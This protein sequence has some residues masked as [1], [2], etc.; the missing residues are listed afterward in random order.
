[1]HTK[2]YSLLGVFRILFGALF[3]YFCMF[4]L[5]FQ[6]PLL[7]HE[8]PFSSTLH[9]SMPAGSVELWNRSRELNSQLAGSDAV[10]ELG[11]IIFFFAFMF[12]LFTGVIGYWAYPARRNMAL[13]LCA[14]N[15]TACVSYTISRL[16]L[17]PV[18]E[19]FMGQPLTP[20]RYVQWSC[21]SSMLIYM[22]ASIGKATDAQ[23]LQA[24]VMEFLCIIT[25]FLGSY[26]AWPWWPI[27]SALS[28]LTYF[29]AVDTMVTSIGNAIAES[30][31]PEI[32]SMLKVCIVLIFPT[33]FFETQRI[34]VFSVNA[35]SACVR[36]AGVD[37]V[38]S[39]VDRRSCFVDFAGG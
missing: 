33:F 21:S 32:T 19:D 15:L 12:D 24:L 17:L 22:I 14:I 6:L 18:L 38:P 27:F 36:V 5:T 3:I 4:Q 2:S 29:S 39:G 26:L 28:F 25:G 20:I 9:A 11:V 35:E 1:M 13:L 7:Q 34:D 37:L 30:T 31:H 23:C 16:G 8:S 10:H